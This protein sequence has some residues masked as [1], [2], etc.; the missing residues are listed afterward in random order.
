MTY[1]LSIRSNVNAI[2]AFPAILTSY[3][4][5]LLIFTCTSR[6]MVNSN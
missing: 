6:F 5:L 4:C 1:S 2:T 3:G